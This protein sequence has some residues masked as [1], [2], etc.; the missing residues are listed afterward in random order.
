MF[1]SNLAVRTYILNRP[2]KLNALDEPMLTLLRPK[3]EVSK[4]ECFDVIC[5]VDFREYKEW[6][7]SDLC[8]TIVGTGVGRAFCAGGDVAS[9]SANVTIAFA[10]T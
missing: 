1:E 5:C 10:D 2:L 3:I 7:A 4:L 6:S 8:G 9:E